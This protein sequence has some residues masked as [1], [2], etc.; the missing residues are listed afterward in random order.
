MKSI[1][2]IPTS[3]I[4]RASKLISTG[5]KVGGNYTKHYAKSLFTDA[6]K[7]E[8]DQRNAAVVYDG[9]KELKGSALKV[10]Q[11]LSME[12]QMLPKAYV[13]QFSLAQFSVPSLS[14]PLVKKVFLTNF[15]KL[16]TQLFDEFEPEASFA[17]TIGQVHRARKGSKNLAV[18]VQYPGVSESVL[19]DLKLVK[20]FAARLFNI[21]LKDAKPYFDEVADKL[22]EETNYTLEL[23]QS[24]FMSSSC[25]HIE[26]LK[27][28]TYYK[29]YSSDRILT[30]DWMEG[31]HLSELH[32]LNLNK[33]QRSALAQSLWDFY[34]FQI[35]QLKKVHADPHPG[36][37]LVT[38]DGNLVPLDFGCIKEIPTEFYEPYFEL[39]HPEVIENEALFSSYLYKLELL[40]ADDSSD[41][42]H[43]ITAIFKDL[44]TVFTRPFGSKTFNFSDQQFWSDINRLS[45]QL[46]EDKTLRKMNGNRGSKHFIYMNRTFF[47]LYHL[48]N[49]LQSTV[50]INNVNW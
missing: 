26:N 27:F 24:I 17:A 4:S 31:V 16:P 42:R 48:M 46:S 44:L 23:E 3:K 36:N 5:V 43:F 15:S 41:T 33:E 49:E 22:L 28:P 30:M 18:K 29:A 6:S 32:K 14:Y 39:I 12:Q 50:V 40:R 45:H 8:L 7:E 21:N 19:S 47:G 34:M 10:A 11:M 37:F 38:T 2:S 20:P 13:E 9:L 35:H 1:D 25:S